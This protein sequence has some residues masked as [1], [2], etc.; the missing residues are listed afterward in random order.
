MLAIL[1]RTG[2]AQMNIMQFSQYVLDQV[3][4]PRNL[5]LSNYESLRKIKGWAT[6]KSARFWPQSS[7]PDAICRIPCNFIRN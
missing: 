1:L 6:L 5:L 2:S 3:G 4:G 7:L